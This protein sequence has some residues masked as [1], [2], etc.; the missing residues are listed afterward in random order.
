MKFNPK[1]LGSIKLITPLGITNEVI[2]VRLKC[3][4]FLKMKEEI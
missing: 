1:S 3:P 4:A 2:Q